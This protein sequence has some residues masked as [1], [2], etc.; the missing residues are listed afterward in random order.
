MLKKDLLN[1][2]VKLNEFAK[3]GQICLVGSGR[4]Q[5][6]KI[7]EMF[8]DYEISKTVYNRSSEDLLI[9]DTAAYCNEY[10]E[11]LQPSKL[12]FYL[13]EK[14]IVQEGITPEEFAEQY[15]WMLYNVHIAF[16]NTKLYIMGLDNAIPDVEVFN[17]QLEKIADECGCRF[18][19]TNNSSRQEGSSYWFFKNMKVCLFDKGI[20]F[21]DAMTV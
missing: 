6:I 21:A 12:V 17:S 2:Y 19:G 13:G 11:A 15:R 7:G 9:R 20:S 14:E 16:K 5:D 18:I 10:V 3:P 4:A 8:S 1:E